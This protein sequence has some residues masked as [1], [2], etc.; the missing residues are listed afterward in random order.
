MTK[1]RISP[2]QLEYIELTERAPK[3]CL[4]AVDRDPGPCN[5]LKPFCA[6]TLANYTVN[7]LT[8]TYVAMLTGAKNF[9]Y[10]RKQGLAKVTAIVGGAYAVRG[11]VR[12]RLEEVK[13]R[14]EQERAARD[15][16]KRRFNQTQDNVSYAVLTLIQT[17]S[18]QILTEMDVEGLTL[19][20]QTRSKARQANKQRLER[21]PSSLASSIDMVQDQDTR[22]EADSAV[23][24]VAS[25]S[26]DVAAA[27]MSNI[28]T[29]GLQSWVESSGTPLPLASETSQ[30]G[31]GAACMSESIATVDSS[32]HNGESSSVAGSVPSESLMSSSIVS[33]S[34]SSRTTAELWNEVKILTFTRT[35]TTL[36]STTLL[37]LLTSIQLTLL[38]RS[39]YTQSVLELERNER[40][41][42][43][44]ASEFTL[45]N[46][47]LKSGRGLEELL[48]GDMSTLLDDESRDEE[49][50][51][52]EVESKFLT[53]SWW[54]LHVGWK[55]VGE[56]VRRGVEEA[57]DGVSLKSKLAAI[58]LHRLVSDVRRR[59]EYEITFEGRERRIDFLSSLLPSTPE[60][61]HHVLTQGGPPPNTL[62]APYDLL[63]FDDISVTSSQLSHSQHP[64]PY[65][66]SSTLSL[67][68][69][70]P[71]DPAFLALLE[72]T[73]SII[74]SSDFAPVLEA[75][76][77]RTTD[78]L[79]AGLEKW[80][81]VSSEP[82]LPPGEP[83]RI[84]LAGLLPGLSRW[85]HLA[86]DALP[87]EL[88]DNIL[89][90]REFEC[91]SAIT[92]A[93]FE[94]RFR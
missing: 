20:L 17:L 57:F 21:P 14:L 92:F 3:C 22:S 87:N 24:S 36:Y 52:E 47:L 28:S 38:A 43:R 33:D 81:F 93:K 59:V 54:I 53:M 15:N 88:V 82:G 5:F 29:S 56:R 77:D 16:L 58:D 42:E 18:E 83:I 74:T 41:Q 8:P 19:E 37:S 62:P 46:M 80:V 26:Y 39:K 51:S 73:R 68:Q 67:I 90:V 23:V 85:S 66:H 75:C 7:R 70:H 30:G 55:D 45:T 60:T 94:D 71:Q 76:L 64:T 65:P 2:G 79:F 91:L 6:E 78:I 10:D 25:T 44:M 69:P 72:E 84:R 9:L 63:E 50:I 40:M 27:S 11:Y 12:N 35:L 48:S 13:D 49:Y 89:A 4:E 34:G 61:V 31:G 86:M 32:T 1:D